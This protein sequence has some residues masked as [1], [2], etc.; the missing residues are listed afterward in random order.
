MAALQ[1]AAG[2]A[3]RQASAFDST[4]GTGTRTET[5]SPPQLGSPTSKA[6]TF[7]PSGVPVGGGGVGGGPVVDGRSTLVVPRGGGVSRMFSRSDT[8]SLSLGTAVLGT[9]SLSASA[10]PRSGAAAAGGNSSAANGGAA[11]AAAARYL[12]E[13]QAALANVASLLVPLTDP[14]KQAKLIFESLDWEFDKTLTSEEFAYIAE[15]ADMRVM[16]SAGGLSRNSG[17]AGDGSAA[18]AARRSMA[19]L[20]STTSMPPALSRQSVAAPGGGGGGV[21]AETSV[22]S[23]DAS[24]MVSQNWGPG[25]DKSGHVISAGPSQAAAAVEDSKIYKARRK[26]ALKVRNRKEFD[27]FVEHHYNR[28]NLLSIETE[29][30]RARF[31]TEL[32]RRCSDKHDSSAVVAWRVYSLLRQVWIAT[33]I[34]CLSRGRR[35]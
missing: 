34:N 27:W 28:L 13:E 31:L 23:F 5:G 30:W 6:V 17:S 18:Q 19:A 25:F 22:L 12:T 10:S 24:T 20:S 26:E 8:Q 29:D 33:G 35:S 32:R 21:T 16:G 11:A 15:F 7:S 3:S 14:R 2:T 1:D 9:Q 4:W